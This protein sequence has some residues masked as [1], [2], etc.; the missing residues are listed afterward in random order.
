MRPFLSDARLLMS[1]NTAFRGYCRKPA[2]HEYDLK[3]VKPHKFFGYSFPCQIQ[4]AL[5]RNKTIRSV[6]NKNDS[7]VALRYLES[8]S[9]FKSHGAISLIE[10]LSGAVIPLILIPGLIHLRCFTR[11]VTTCS[12]AENYLKCNRSEVFPEI[13]KLSFISTNKSDIDKLLKEDK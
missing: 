13:K 10:I 9:Q 3:T 11:D 4:S 6:K 8:K 7:E 12:I 1:C 5:L 2:W